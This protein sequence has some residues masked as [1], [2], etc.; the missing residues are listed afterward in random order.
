[1][2]CRGRNDPSKK[3][4]LS[5]LPDLS[6]KDGNHSN[7]VQA[8]SQHSDVAFIFFFPSVLRLEALARLR[9]MAFISSALTDVGTTQSASQ[10][11]RRAKRL[12]YITL[13]WTGV[14]LAGGLVAGVSASSISLL[15]FGA[16]SGI[17][18]ALSGLLL[19]RLAHQDSEREHTS[20]STAL[21]WA[22]ISFLAVAAL[23]AFQAVASLIKFH[24]PFH[25]TLG[26]AVT[27]AALILMPVIAAA[28]R[29]AARKLGSDA[30]H[31]DAKQNSFCAYQAAIVLAGLLLYRLFGWW[32][33]DA[34]AALILVPLM[35]YEGWSALQGQ[36]CGCAVH[37]HPHHS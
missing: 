21:R 31:T 5:T 11:Q 3:P 18:V 10:W 23:T 32:W 25:S 27:C 29:Q 16:Q 26:L 13:A 33:A 7:R 2:N 37:T 22:G 14:E 19:W 12:E 34:V 8:G 4:G 24:S 1:M 6:C 9:R 17:E 28:K 15:S 30:L 20:E 36:P 35:V